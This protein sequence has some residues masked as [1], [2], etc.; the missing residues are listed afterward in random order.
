MKELITNALKTAQADYCEI[1]LEETHVT[2]VVYRG[3]TLDTIS[4]NI[5]YGGNV[6]ALV[7]GGWGFVSFNKLENLSEYVEAACQ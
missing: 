1:R 6:R 2:S 3:K 4:Q 5:Q 7:N